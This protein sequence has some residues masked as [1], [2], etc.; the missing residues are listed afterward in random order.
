MIYGDIFFP[1]MQLGIKKEIG[2][3]L[4]S[5]YTCSE[6]L[7]ALMNT[8]PSNPINHYKNYTALI[9]KKSIKVEEYNIFR[10][11]IIRIIVTKSFLEE[12]IEVWSNRYH[13]SIIFNL[14]K[15][16]V[17]IFSTTQFWIECFLDT[18]KID[19]HGKQQR[20]FSTYT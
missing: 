9:L 14:S 7:N 12:S 2:K 15:T 1:L 11:E 18:F 16:T 6:L 19:F 10:N 20:F 4:K 13:E 8:L 5:K 3:P 17:L